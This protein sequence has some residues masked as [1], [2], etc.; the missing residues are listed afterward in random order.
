MRLC[1]LLLL[2]VTGCSDAGTETVFVTKSCSVVTNADQSIAIKCP[3]GDSVIVPPNVVT[4]IEHEV[5]E[6]P[7]VIIKEVKCKKHKGEH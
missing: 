2:A 3:S 7:I 1:L 6:V 4:V 5:V